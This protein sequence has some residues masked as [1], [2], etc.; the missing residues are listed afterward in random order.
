MSPTV[1]MT[2]NFTTTVLAIVVTGALLNMA[3]KGTF[4]GAAKNFANYVTSGYGAGSL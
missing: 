4:G 3:N 1:F 2:K